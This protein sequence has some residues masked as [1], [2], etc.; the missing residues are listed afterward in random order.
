MGAGQEA[1]VWAPCF[2]LVAGP[3]CTPLI[4]FACLRSSAVGVQPDQGWPHTPSLSQ[5][6]HLG[7]CLAF[8]FLSSGMKVRVCLLHP[9]HPPGVL[10]SPCLIARELRARKGR[11][12]DTPQC[13]TLSVTTM[14]GVWVDHAGLCLPV[15]LTLC[16][17]GLAGLACQR[18]KTHVGLRS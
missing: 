14:P 9:D 10:P 3:R 2:S 13:Q 6:L 12:A 17:P 1:A 11:S 15:F 4:H 8:V 7:E 18:V 5:H 16:S